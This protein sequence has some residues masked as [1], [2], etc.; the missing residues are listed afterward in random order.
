MTS[1]YSLTGSGQTQLDKYRP[2]TASQANTE[3]VKQNTEDDK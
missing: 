3:R 2:Y 1:K